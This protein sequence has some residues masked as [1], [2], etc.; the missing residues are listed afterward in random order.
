MVYRIHMSH[1]GDLL[2]SLGMARQCSCLGSGRAACRAALLMPSSGGSSSSW[3]LEGGRSRLTALFAPYTLALSKHPALPILSAFAYTFLSSV[4]SFCFLFLCLQLS[5]ALAK[6]CLVGKE[7][8][9]PHFVP[10]TAPIKPRSV[11]ISLVLLLQQ[12]PLIPP[13]FQRL[14]WERLCRSQDAQRQRCGAL[15]FDCLR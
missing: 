15:P 11:Q 4:L 13:C 14:G 6:G 2:G 5:K 3:V 7:L 12:Q 10:S 9:G 1:M 8:L